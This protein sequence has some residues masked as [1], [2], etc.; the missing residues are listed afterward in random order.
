MTSETQGTARKR[1]R[2]PKV[3]MMEQFAKA[4]REQPDA[5]LFFR[6]GDFYE[7]FGEDAKVAS[8]ELGIAL[9]SRSKGPNAIPMAG[10]PVKSMG[11]YLMRLVQQG[12]KVAICEQMEDPRTTKGIVDRAIVRVVTAGTITEEDVLDARASN[13]LACLA[14][15]E[16]RAGQA[17]AGLAWVD[18]S[19]GRLHASEL[20]GDEIE[21]ELA[22]LA[23]AELL[24][25]ES[26]A[27]SHPE[28]A[29]RLGAEFGPRLTDREAWRFERDA[30]LRVLRKQFG[31]AT[32]K[33]FG[34]EDD[35]PVVAA[36][37]ALVEYLQ[38]T[39]RGACD[40]VLRLERVDPG[41]HLVLD[42]ATR[43]TLELTITQRDA[44]R[45]GTLLDTIDRSLTPMGGRLLREWVLSPL[46]EVDAILYRQRGVAELVE[47]PFLREDV[48]ELLSDVLDV[49]RLVA[50]V[51][52]GRAN[53]RDLVALAGSLGVVRPLLDKLESVYS[54]VLGDLRESLDPLD[55]LVQRVQRTLV[56]AP[57]LTLKEGSLV[58]DGV[59]AE[60]DELRQIAGDGKAWMARFQ[61]Q[62][63]E[64]TG[65]ANL[66][67]GFNSVFG[68]YLEVPR[69][70]ID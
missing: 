37:G 65:M 45:E 34:F 48:R 25:P 59:D 32:L 36:A 6:M 67:V 64:R 30:C 11:G 4:K 49:E 7:L 61:A 52:T 42:R 54:S 70:Q 10:V 41:N 60:L 2:K 22:R 9:T 17:C 69:G 63:I 46:R 53:G 26:M 35:S 44:R 51:S 24:W 31:V 19:T 43:S 50:K 47:A 27:E 66:K 20:A 8:R 57:P 3:T 56:D 58:R 68:Y 15:A 38:E 28:L 13:W 12:H 39:Q 33:G 5:L 62:E 14:P 16:R 40:H 29:R 1:G 23:P 18:I 55:E 21:D